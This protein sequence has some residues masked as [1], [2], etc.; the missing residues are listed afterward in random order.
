MRALFTASTGMDAQ[1]VRI[2]TIA[3]NLANVGTTGFKRQRAEF[4]DLFYDTLRDPGVEPVLP[5]Q[6]TACRV[7]L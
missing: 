7:C 5:M 3:N 6:H 4:Q 1:Q 2:D